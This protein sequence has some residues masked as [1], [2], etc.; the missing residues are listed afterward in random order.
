MS[1]FVHALAG[2][3]DDAFNSFLESVEFQDEGFSKQAFVL[4]HKSMMDACRMQFKHKFQSDLDAN[5]LLTAHNREL[6][7]DIF[8]TLEERGWEIDK[9]FVDHPEDSQLIIEFQDL[10]GQ[11]LQKA[12]PKFSDRTIAFLKEDIR[13]RFATQIRRKLLKYRTKYAQLRDFLEDELIEQQVQ[14]QRKQ[15]YYLNIRSLYNQ[16]VLGDARMTLADLYIEPG[17]RIHTRNYIDKYG[18]RDAEDFAFPSVRDYI[19]N[20]FLKQKLKFQLEAESNRLLLLLGQPGQG[21][22]S[23]CYRLINDCQSY[24]HAG[25]ELVFI[26]LRE[27]ENIKDFVQNPFDEIK[28]HHASLEFKL[29]DSIIILDGLDEIYMTTGLDDRDINELFARLRRRLERLPDV[30]CIVTSRYHY[31]KPENLSKDI[32]FLELLPLDLSQQIQWLE[33][34]QYFN[35]TCTLNV[36]LLERISKNEGGKFKEIKELV[37]QPIL[38]NLIANADF[39]I[40][41]DANKSLIYKELF[42]TLINRTWSE[43][44][45]LDFLKDVNQADFRDFIGTIALKI[46]QSPNEYLTSSQLRALPE[47]ETFIKNNLSKAEDLD[48]ALKQVLISFYFQEVDPFQREREHYQEKDYSI[49]FLH[50]SLQEYLAAERIYNYLKDVFTDQGRREY[51]INTWQDALKEVWNLVHQK[52]ISHEV[53]AYLAEIIENDDAPATKTELRDRMQHFF[54]DLLARQFLFKYDVNSALDQPMLQACTVFW[55][56]WQV[57]SHLGFDYKDERWDKEAFVDMLTMNQH[58]NFQSLYLNGAILKNCMLKG[59]DLEGANLEATDLFLS[60]LNGANLRRA[61]LKKASLIGTNLT[62][63]NL[64][65]SLLFEAF[66]FAT[67]LLGVELYGASLFRANL[68]KANLDMADLIGANLN[69]AHLNKT[70]L[71]GA[72][73]EG[74]LLESTRNLTVKQLLLTESLYHIQG[75]DP[76]LEAELRKQKPCLF[77]PDGCEE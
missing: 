47:T 36:P 20:H 27:L 42:D 56:Y 31:A 70:T 72:N 41:E 22:T 39:E 16:S 2:S 77:E 68:E 8:K 26:K 49:E 74:A 71:K 48:K 65:E 5:R 14:M 55:V 15:E 40:N 35:P 12:Y 3:T 75:L 44:G 10:Y 64:N 52:K 67:M 32:L 1:T 28:K 11:W 57:L 24:Y 54:P 69:N 34:Y 4:I 25:K 58:I 62:G 46:Y 76:K 61:N 13:Y 73:L 9:A 17:M 53:S 18:E 19:T 50:K 33:N 43:E 45:Q 66:L 23:F 7:Y 60:K 30:F 37:E 59:A 6:D 63:A 21:K 38:L 51:I 29:E